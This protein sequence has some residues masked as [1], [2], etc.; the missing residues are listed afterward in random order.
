MKCEEM[1]DLLH[2]YVDGELDLVRSLEIENHLEECPACSRAVEKL[3]ALRARLNSAD[4]YHRA[5]VQLKERI[6]SAL[7][8]AARSGEVGSVRNAATRLR[9]RRG[10]AVAAAIALVFL[11][12][13][14]ALRVLTVPSA[15]D[16][17]A[18]ELVA[19]HVRSLA[20]V[21]HLVDVPSSDRHTVKPWF[22]DKVDFAPS[23]EDLGPKGFALVGG[24]LDYLNGRK[25][26]ALVYQRHKHVINL[27]IWP[28]SPD[29]K[30]T[31]L[32]LTRQGY[33]LIHWTN[34]GL[35][36]WAISDLNEQELQEF[37][38]LMQGP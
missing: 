31:P 29:M 32:A 3:Q 35:N 14:G 37:V 2:G 8:G 24:R 11:G 9:L 22:S 34:S 33:H 19:S 1:K 23:V 21:S 10:L 20:L 36:Y 7:R 18:Q 13:W 16:L 30:Q 4:L 27:F 28:A 38:Q 17:L 26:A 6:R 25:V 15:Q 5:P 12:G